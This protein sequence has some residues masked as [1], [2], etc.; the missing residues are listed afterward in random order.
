MSLFR[1]ITLI[2]T[3]GME[4]Y[5]KNCGESQKTM[6]PAVIT[7]YIT[8]SRKSNMAGNDNNNNN[9]FF[10]IYTN[11]ACSISIPTFW[12]SRNAMETLEKSSNQ[13][14]IK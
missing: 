4:N 1:Q 8:Y 13:W 9:N 7:A 2:I 14:L 3:A 6:V 5:Q 12:G 10:T 11:M